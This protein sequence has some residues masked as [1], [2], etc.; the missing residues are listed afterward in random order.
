MNDGGLDCGCT[1]SFPC[2]RH[3]VVSTRGL[4]PIPAKYR[5]TGRT[6]R[7]LERCVERAA[8]GER[9]YY[10]TIHEAHARSCF[11]FV[12]SYL[13]DMDGERRPDYAGRAVC[14]RSGGSL[15]IIGAEFAYDKLLRSPD[16][17][18]VVIDHA[19]HPGSKL[20]SLL[21]YLETVGKCVW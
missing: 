13:K 2:P 4:P 11:Q 14:F 10:V 16:S 17:F 1:S 19:T 8:A 7:A 3:P 9:V 15:T 12:V 20:Y 21:H 18:A 6:T 5:G